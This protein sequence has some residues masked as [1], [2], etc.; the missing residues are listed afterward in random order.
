[1]SKKITGGQFCDGLVAKT[2]ILELEFAELIIKM[3]QESRLQRLRELNLM[4]NIWRNDNNL[5][6]FAFVVNRWKY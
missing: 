1:M 5:F 2:E 6:R 3:L 4:W